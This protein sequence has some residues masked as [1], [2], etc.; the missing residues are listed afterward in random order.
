MRLTVHAKDLHRGDVLIATN[1]IVRAVSRP[2][3]PQ[4]RGGGPSRVVVGLY[5]EAYTRS[6]NARTTLAIHRDRDHAE[7]VAG[8]VAQFE[9]DAS[10]ALRYFDAHAVR[11]VFD[12][13]RFEASRDT[14]VRL[15]RLVVSLAREVAQERLT[16]GAIC[17][18]R[19]ATVPA[20]ARENR[21]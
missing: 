21:P 17:P 9:G 7:R 4:W 13:A 5:G 19:T 20:V 14:A 15:A 16:A 18:G 11:Q 6:W 1:R 12:A 3:A 8:A 10:L 2:L